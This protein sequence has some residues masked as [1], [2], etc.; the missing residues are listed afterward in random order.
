M[1][2]KASLTGSRPL[3]PFIGNDERFAAV[4]GA[5]ASVVGISVAFIYARAG[6]TL[7]HYD[8]KAHLV[9]ARRVLDSLTPGWAQVGAIWLPLPHLLNVFPVQIDM[10]YRTG[11]SAVAMSVLAFAV[12][13]YAAARLVL[14]ITGSRLGATVALLALAL[15]PNVLYLQATPMTEPLLLALTLLGVS[16]I[17]DW[18]VRDAEG[19]PHAAGWTLAAACMTRYESWFVTATLFAGVWYVLWRRGQPSIHALKIASRLVWYPAAAIVAF[20]I[21]SRITIGAWFVTSGFFVPDNVARGHL[22]KAAG[23][24]IWGTRILTGN[25]LFALG[26]CGAAA[27]LLIAGWSR[28]RRELFIALAL[29]AFGAL[30]LYAFLEGHPF[31]IRYM[32]PLVSAAAVFAGVATGLTGRRWRMTTGVL[33]TIALLLTAHP[34]DP[35]APMVVEAQWDHAN[36]IGR[37]QVTE[38]LMHSYHGEKILVS[39]GSLAHYMQEL[40]QQHLA[41]RDFVHEGNDQIWRGALSEPRTV[42]GWILIEEQAEGGDALAARAK[43]HPD[44]LAGFHRACEGGGVALYQADERLPTFANSQ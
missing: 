21:H 28:R 32:V 14:Q 33:V 40:S 8:A 1:P 41:I 7:S 23:Q 35:S 10:L 11:L 36:S 31:R 5:V 25:V 13:C 30:P 3:A 37:Q 12:A 34:L 27:T 16:L 42:V 24:V 18:V 19:V 26:A 2:F 43:E 44:F 39:M 4:A 17:Y 6:L 9:V 20:T 22:F 29:I 15:N 38:C